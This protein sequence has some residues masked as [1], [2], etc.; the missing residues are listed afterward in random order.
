M[1]SNQF[2][3]LERNME[4][5]KESFE[6]TIDYYAAMKSNYQVDR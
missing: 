3:F 6:Q 2:I 5:D 4:R 1:S